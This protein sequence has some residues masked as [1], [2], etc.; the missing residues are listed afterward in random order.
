[1]ELHKP[2]GPEGS[3]GRNL[4]TRPSSNSGY[5][6][7]S[8][9]SDFTAERSTTTREGPSRRGDVQRGLHGNAGDPGSVRGYA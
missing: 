2:S 8:F 4:E 3:S 6:P 5:R 1:M 9:A 7:R